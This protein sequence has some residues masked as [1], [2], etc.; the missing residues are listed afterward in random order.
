MPRTVIATLPGLLR[1]IILPLRADVFAFCSGDNSTSCDEF[2]RALRSSP[3]VQLRAFDSLTRLK[4]RASN[5]TALYPYDVMAPSYLAFHE[6]WRHR[7][8]KMMKQFQG[9]QFV[10]VRFAWELARTSESAPRGGRPL[11]CH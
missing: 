5:E 10:M 1:D 2:E 8:G 3:G 6:S 7:M 9:M 11:L 4:Q